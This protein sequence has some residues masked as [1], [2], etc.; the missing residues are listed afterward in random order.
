LG[1]SKT[2]NRILKPFRISDKFS[3]ADQLSFVLGWIS[4]ALMALSLGFAI[5]DMISVAIQLFLGGVA[6]VFVI[7]AYDAFLL[8]THV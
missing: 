6:M 5:K 2:L 3:V 1:K 8:K 4:I 7:L